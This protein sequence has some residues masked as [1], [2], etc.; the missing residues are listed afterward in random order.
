MHFLKHKN[1]VDGRDIRRQLRLDAE[2]FFNVSDENGEESDD[3]TGPG[4][5]EFDANE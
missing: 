3:K 4:L 1:L 2:H 5:N